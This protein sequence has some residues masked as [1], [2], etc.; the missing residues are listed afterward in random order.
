MRNALIV[1]II[2]ILGAGG[3]LGWDWYDK[4]QKQKLEP[5]ITLYYWTDADGN[6]HISDVAPPQDARSVYK[7][8]GYK[9]IKPPLIVTIKNKAVEY[10]KKAKKKLFKPGKRK[11]K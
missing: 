9:Y 6:K 10:Y 4:T 2:I 8:K 11:T 5:S 7:D 1:I 3:F